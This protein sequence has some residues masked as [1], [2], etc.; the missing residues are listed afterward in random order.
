MKTARENG[1]KLVMAERAERVYNDIFTK[2]GQKDFSIV[3]K[4][5]QETNG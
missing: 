4:W 2:D 3:F 5:L 1:A